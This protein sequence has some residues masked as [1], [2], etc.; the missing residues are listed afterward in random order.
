MF[1]VLILAYYFPP[2]G[3]SGVQRTLKFAKYMSDYNWKPTVIT[4]GKT[5]YFAHD[6]SLL[7]EAEESD[8]EIIRTDSYD[9]NALLAKQGT[10]KMPNE[11]VR[12]TLSS[13]SKTIF[14]PDNK[15]SWSKRAYETAKELLSKEKFDIIYV[16]VPPFSAFMTAAKLRKEFNIPL[17]VDYRDLWYGNQYAFYPTF[18]HK[19]KH[20]ALETECLRVAD[21]II[22]VNRRVKEKL[23]TTYNFLNHDE[24]EIIPHG[25]DSADFKEI[26]LT[27]KQSRVN[28]NKIRLTYS[29]IFYESV[30]PKHFLKA[31]K[32]LTIDRPDVAANYE[33]HFVGYLRNE[34]LRLIQKLKLKEYVF[35]QGYLDHKDAVRKLMESDVLWMTLGNNDDMQNVTPGKL[36]EY[37]GTRKPVLALVPDGASANSAREYGASFVCKP[38]D[39]EGIIS[40]LVSIHDKFIRKTLPTPNED[41][42]LSHDRKE[43]TNKLVKSFQFYLEETTS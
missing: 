12:K 43:L 39:I 34:N 29:G 3:M 16:T 35:D 27:E 13:I 15:L 40:A 31:F 5:G 1:K 24:V 10:I 11:K 22:A 28:A 41:F 19:A 30:T 9:P 25:Y 6:T 26:K 4:T 32:K 14:I 33:L 36:Y 2:L 38:D 18:Y 17:F 42:V 7:K 21:K 20:K 8:I 37:F 23:L